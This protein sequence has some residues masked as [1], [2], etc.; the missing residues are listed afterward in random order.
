MTCGKKE[1]YASD[2]HLSIWMALDHIAKSSK[3]STSGLSKRVGLDPTT[4]NFSKRFLS[5]GAAR[6]PSTRTIAFVCYS[7]NIDTTKFYKLV[8]NFYAGLSTSK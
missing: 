8:D 5:N 6:W 7:A 2:M 4:F 1:K 3:L